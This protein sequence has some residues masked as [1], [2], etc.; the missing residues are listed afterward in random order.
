MKLEGGKE[1]P[2]ISYM[3]LNDKA[4]ETYQAAALSFYKCNSTSP[5]NDTTYYYVLL[6]KG[7]IRE[8]DNLMK[9]AETYEVNYN[10]LKKTFEEYNQFASTGID[11][12]TGLY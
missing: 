2:I 5:S 1:G 6:A 8:H 9:F 12:K 3:L 4:V 7:L 10:N 11:E